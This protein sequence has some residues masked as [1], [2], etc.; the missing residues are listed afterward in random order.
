M[1]TVVNTKKLPVRPTKVRGGISR[2]NFL[3]F[4][5]VTII[6]FMGYNFISPDA[7]DLGRY[8]ETAERW[9]GEK[10]KDIAESFFERSVDFI[11]Y[12]LLVLFG[13]TFVGAEFVTGATVALYYFMIMWTFAR[14]VRRITLTNVIYFVGLFSFPNFIWVVS[15][16]RNA[17]A[18]MFIFAGVLFWLKDKKIITAIF[19]ILAAFTHF[20]VLIYVALFFLSLLLYKLLS[21]KEKLVSILCFILPPLM[22]LLSYYIL[23]NF[24]NSTLLN[25]FLGESHYTTYSDFA[26]ENTDYSFYGYG[27][28]SVMYVTLLSTYI[29]LNIDKKVSTRKVLLLVFGSITIGMFTAS[30]AFFNR[31]MICLPIFYSLYFSELYRENV[32]TSPSHHNRNVANVMLFNSMLSIMSLILLWYSY[33][34]WTLV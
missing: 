13:N 4:I 14:Y 32:L 8:Y 16:S 9:Q 33:R 11:Y 23:D 5:L 31:F 25:A 19:F 2:K 7:L 28:K 21:K 26:G 20:S 29:L 22:Y 27:D 15:I 30:A 3:I 6:F 18:I 24:L 1:E 17:M 10:I 12:V 34:M